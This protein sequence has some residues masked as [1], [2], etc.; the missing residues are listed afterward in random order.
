MEPATSLA[1]PEPAKSFQGPRTR[2]RRVWGGDHLGLHGTHSSG[3]AGGSPSTFFPKGLIVSKPLAAASPG[4]R[5]GA[6]SPSTTARWLV[7]GRRGLP[8]ERLGPGRASSR[9]ARAAAWAG[10]RGHC[11]RA[12]VRGS[13][14]AACVHRAWARGGALRFLRDYFLIWLLC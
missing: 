12:G 7:P 11:A 1:L 8:P 9:G 3:P 10:E 4:P 13:A 2:R 14:C 6:S 5:W